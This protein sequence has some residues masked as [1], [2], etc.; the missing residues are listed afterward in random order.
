MGGVNRKRSRMAIISMVLFVVFLILG[1][2]SWNSFF[3]ITSMLFLIVWLILF[4]TT[5]R[6]PYC[7]QHFPEFYWSKPSAG[8][9]RKC[10]NLMEYDDSI[11]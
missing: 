1:R 10:G 8:Y 9:C 7:G 6:C 3:I 11:K 5:N 2:I 4:L